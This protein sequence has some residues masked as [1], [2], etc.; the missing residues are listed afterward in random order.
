MMKK[1]IILPLFI[2]PGYL[3]LSGCDLSAVLS[4]TEGEYHNPNGRLQ[5]GNTCSASDDCIKLCAS[6]LQNLSDQQD[7]YE[8]TESEVQKLRDTYNLLALGDERKLEEIV[9]E[10]M[11]NFLKFGPV[12]WLDAISGFETGRKDTDDCANIAVEDLSSSCK[13]DDYYQQEGYDVE[14][15]RNT[16]EWMSKSPWLTEYLKRHDTELLILKNLFYCALKADEDDFCFE[17]SEE[18]LQNTSRLYEPVFKLE[19][20]TQKQTF[21]DAII[22]LLALLNNTNAVSDSIDLTDVLNGLVSEDNE[23][24]DKPAI[25]YIL[26]HDISTEAEFLNFIHEEVVVN[27][28]CGTD[29]PPDSLSTFEPECI[30]E[31]YCRAGTDDDANEDRAKIAE[32]INERSVELYI[33]LSGITI[34]THKWTAE[35]CAL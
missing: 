34:D 32:L 31:V 9:I 14:G 29:P 18:E 20:E 7:C 11:D 35:A 19:T 12:L 27:R 5:S 17:N 3:T 10:E 16:L 1:L 23:I 22:Y 6:M 30:L 26:D 15:A 33:Q 2:I 4:S 8:L 28:L 25:F 24:E 21:E 13:T